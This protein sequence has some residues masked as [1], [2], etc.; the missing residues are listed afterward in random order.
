MTTLNVQKGD[1]PERGTKPKLLTSLY[2]VGLA[3]LRSAQIPNFERD[4]LRMQVNGPDGSVFN[5]KPW[6]PS[7]WPREVIPTDVEQ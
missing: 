7:W 5:V 4:E 6:M 1:V 2:G 3:T